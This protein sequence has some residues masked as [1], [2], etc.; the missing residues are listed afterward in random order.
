MDDPALPA[1]EHRTALAALG[2][3]NRVSRV[4]GQLLPMVMQEAR[5]AAGADTSVLDVACGSADVLVGL[6]AACRARGA[7]LRLAGVDMSATAITVADETS[8]RSGIAATFEQRDV[9]ATGLSQ[10]D[11]SVDV[12]MSSLFLHHLNERDIVRVLREMSRVAARRVLVSDLRRC[13]MGLLAAHLAGSLGTRSRI[14]RVDA[15]RSVQGALTPNELRELSREA[16]LTNARIRE[17]WP[18]RMI[19]DWQRS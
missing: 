14:V 3:V 4:V 7:T 18:F 8:T 1:A 5:R 11:A 16:G 15:V 19:L 13:T 9:V 12:V 6:G 2:R 10:A 17:C